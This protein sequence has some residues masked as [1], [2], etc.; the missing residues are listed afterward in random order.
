MDKRVIEFL[1][2][3]IH[4]PCGSV[5]LSEYEKHIR[6]EAGDLLLQ[7]ANEKL[8]Q[9]GAYGRTIDRW[10]DGFYTERRRPLAS[11]TAKM[12]VQEISQTIATSS[13]RG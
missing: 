3:I 1:E 2:G 6:N 10:W 4:G 11:D 7:I 13:Q 5:P 9:A 12:S 8:A